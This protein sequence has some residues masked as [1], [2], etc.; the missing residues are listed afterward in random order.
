MSPPLTSHFHG[1]DVWVVV[2]FL[3]PWVKIQAPVVVVV[4]LGNHLDLVRNLGY[5]V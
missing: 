4:R 1:L 2:L 3:N 5:L